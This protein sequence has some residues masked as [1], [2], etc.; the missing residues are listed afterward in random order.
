MRAQVAVYL[1]R[2]TKKWLAK[3]GKRLRMTQSE[4]ARALVEREQEIGWLQWAL[5]V[6]D[7]AQKEAHMPLKRPRNRLPRRIKQPPRE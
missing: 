7:P 4:I 6:R 5:K 2:D 1:H 3:Y